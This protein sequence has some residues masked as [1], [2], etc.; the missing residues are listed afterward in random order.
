M[1]LNAEVQCL[2]SSFAQRRRT[3]L[4]VRGALLSATTLVCG[5]VLAA[6]L[7]GTLILE[8][9][10]R[11]ITSFL[12]L[13]AILAVAWI[14]AGKSLTQ[15]SS[16]RLL[17]TLLEKA[18]PPLSG[19]L[20]S[21]VELGSDPDTGLDSPE[22]RRVLQD[23][24]GKVASTLT[25]SSLLPWSVLKRDAQLAGVSIG[26][27]LL[28]FALD[29][30]RFGVRCAR[31]LFPFA[32]FQRPSDTTITLISPDA[33]NAIVAAEDDLNVLAQITGPTRS[34]PFIEY[35]THANEVQRLPM[36]QNETDL[37]GAK[38]NIGSEPVWFRI[39]AGSA[40]TRKVRV[41]PK[42]RPK[43]VWFTQT[44]HPPAYSELPER[45]VAS[46]EGGIAG[47]EGTWVD[48]TIQSDQ[49]LSGGSLQLSSALGRGLPAIL[50]LSGGGTSTSTRIQLK[51]NGSYSVCLIDA[52][53]GF[54]S[55]PGS[56]YEIRSE[57]DNP[58]SVVL[59]TPASDMAVPLGNKVSL[60]GRAEDDLGLAAVFQEVQ[61][62]KGPW[63]SSRAIE[64]PGKQC[65]FQQLWDPISSNPKSG[66]L[67]SFRL[68]AVDTK[69][70]RVES[71]AVQIALVTPEFLP[72]QPASLAAQRKVSR[73]LDRAL[74]QTQLAAKALSEAKAESEARAQNPIKGDQALTRGKQA[75]EAALDYTEAART[76][77]LDRLRNSRSTAE[78]SE[79]ALQ[80]RALDQLEFGQLNPALKA[81]NATDSIPRAE[82]RTSSDTEPLRN[83]AELVAR[84]ASLLQTVQVAASTQLDRS[85]AS[86]L[87]PA[88][89][90]L[91]AEFSS[92]SAS[93]PEA[94]S[95][96]MEKE[97]LTALTQEALR[98][99]Q[100]NQ[101][102]SAALQSDLQ[103]LTERSPTATSALKPANTALKAAQS[104]AQ[105]ALAQAQLSPVGSNVIETTSA[106]EDAARKLG[107]ALEKTG[108]ALEAAQPALRVA[109]AQ[110]QRKLQNE[111]QSSA[112]TIAQTARELD[113]L[114]N[115]KQLSTETRNSE[116]A[117]KLQAAAAVLR[118]DADL[119]S[120]SPSATPQLARDLHAAAVA[121][122]TQLEQPAPTEGAT[123]QVKAAAKAL[124]ALE[125]IAAIE[126]A[127]ILAEGAAREDMAQ[128]QSDKHSAQELRDLVAAKIATLPEQLQ[129]AGLAAEVVAASNEAKTAT[130]NPDTQ[131]S[132]QQI[133]EAL[134]TA[135]NTAA[136]DA[137][138]AREQLESLAPSLSSRLQTLADKSDAAS[139]S[140]TQLAQSN[141]SKAPPVPKEALKA[142]AS[143]AE[144]AEQLR[145]E[146][147][148]VASTQDTLRAE[149]RE[150]ARDA[151]D[152]AALLKDSNGALKSL[153]QA[154]ASKAD[155]E[156][157]LK[158]AA[159]QQAQNAARLRQLA[160][161][162]NNAQSGNNEALSQSRKALR[163][164]EHQTGSRD[165]LAARQAQ[166]EKL[167]AMASAPQEPGNAPADAPQ[168]PASAP[169]QPQQ[170]SD[171]NSSQQWIQRAQQAA[172]DGDSAKS[173]AA[174]KSA[175]QAQ[176]SENR[177]AR[178]AEDAK[179][180]RAQRS[181]DA[182]SD[183]GSPMAENSNSNDLPAGASRSGKAWG[184]LP[185]KLAHDLTEGRRESSPSEYRSAIDAYF[186]AVAERARS[187]K[188]K[189]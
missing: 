175:A 98:K 158:K 13:L 174:I 128:S 114:T 101:T 149:G 172:K 145:K 100:V 106:A 55:A 178:S 127:K 166:S 184:A 9:Q 56:S 29:G 69:G 109:A 155:A 77:A 159:D 26:I 31:I 38:L 65:D 147:Q 50:P 78:E 187:G 76:T 34:A 68:V 44:Y 30:A 154:N 129:K 180:N 18:S 95:T 86:A 51:E 6:V 186:Q 67:L 81:L 176:Q 36:H 120:A 2:L 14:R 45:T 148:A 10:P 151:D 124:S 146:L 126:E 130:A 54:S 169:S 160:E 75:L 152:A 23:Q 91:A 43:V 144:K 41:T 123:K 94:N 137:K 153:Q 143:F 33:P 32:D 35:V 52:V 90:A 59:D 99:Q 21:A 42:P 102:A 168:Q 96:P 28:C 138:Q 139:K 171:P 103:A 162:F 189:P 170:A 112:A 104:A 64:R 53:T 181:A 83:A 142:E 37:F 15:A 1:K 20:L 116:A 173:A 8:D 133:A 12:L 58:P 63:K 24:T 85:E 122:E 164:S 48:L 25:A 141:P 27:L 121:I 47:L 4:F 88:L 107:S 70:Q 188:S 92:P 140:T 84:A 108:N 115:R 74:K 17:A 5:I 89:N 136:P 132:R 46:S 156:Q 113:S 7:D 167:A 111:V 179:K 161:H 125:A 60:I 119:E 117:Q 49:P 80:I 72:I 105:T 157:F 19:S 185:Q 11:R 22:F 97:E 61:L 131:A 57:P 79:I 82:Q 177:L 182:I 71:R 39:H 183:D 135:A 16:S 150:N 134:N 73:E 110:A 87:T 118:A 3:L 163:D 62:N 93:P 40:L 165:V 66:D